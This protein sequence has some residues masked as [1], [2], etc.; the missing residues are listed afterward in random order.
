MNQTLLTKK[1]G[2]NNKYSGY[3]YYKGQVQNKQ[4]PNNKQK[5]ALKKQNKDYHRKTYHRLSR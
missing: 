5:R 4:Q 2:I 3:F 1:R